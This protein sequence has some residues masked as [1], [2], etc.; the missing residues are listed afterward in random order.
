MEL[1]EIG[2]P[3]GRCL[4]AW[5]LPVDSL[6]QKLF[7]ADLLGGLR[8]VSHCSL[9]LEVYLPGALFLTLGGPRETS[10]ITFRNRYI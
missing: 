2:K 5:L 9:V 7:G 8:D 6:S 3:L 10:M 1:F 4:E